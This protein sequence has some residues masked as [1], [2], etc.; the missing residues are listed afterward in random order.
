M[1][2]AAAVLV[3]GGGY[4]IKKKMDED[5]LRSG[6]KSLPQQMSVVDLERDGPGNNIYIE[7]AD[8]AAGGTYVY[9]TKGNSK[10]W[11]TVWIPL[12][13]RGSEYDK[14]LSALKEGDP[15]PPGPFRVILKS[16]HIVDERS[17]DRELASD[18]ITGMVINDIEE[19]SG[20]ERRLLEKHYPGVDIDRCWIFQDGRKPKPPGKGKLPG[21]IMIVA[22]IALA[23]WIIWSFVQA[24]DRRERAYESR[25]A[26]REARR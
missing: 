25:V 1:I 13:A 20:E 23:A 4:W 9:E 7:L 18:S 16:G 15:M 14:R 8:F 19:M 6:A 21:A 3:F 5:T 2:V 11:Q 17:L 22:G 26:R 24:R 12:I 10:Y